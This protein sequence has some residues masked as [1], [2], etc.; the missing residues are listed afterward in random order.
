MKTSWKISRVGPRPAGL[1]ALGVWAATCLTFPAALA[2]E[3]AAKPAVALVIDDTP[4]A[5]DIKTETSFAPVAKNAAAA[6]VNVFTTKKVR[7]LRP[8]DLPFSDDPFFRRFFRD[9]ERGEAQPRTHKERSLGSG[10]IVSRDG[11]IL[12]NDHVVDGADEVKVTLAKEKKVYTAKVVGKDSKT[13]IA[14]LKIEASGLPVA[15]LTDS[16]KLE[17]G[18]VLLAIGNPFGVGQTVT[19]GI[20]SAV[21]RGDMG[22][23]DYEDFIQ[24]DAAVNPGNS[25]GALVDAQGRLVGINTAI[26]SGTGGNLGIG[27]AIPV[28]MAR[29]VMDRLVKEGRVVRGYLGVA[30]QDLTPELAK[31][32]GAPE[33]GGAL[34]TDVTGKSAA[35]EAG[36]KSGDVIIEF[37]DKPV[38]DSRRLRLLVARSSP[39]TKAIVKL[40][41]QGKEKT[42]KVTLGEA[43]DQTKGEPAESGGEAPDEVLKD[44][45]VGEIDAATRR[46]F[47]LP[48]ELKGALVTE[49]APDSPAFEAGL[50]PGDVIQEVN[51]KRIETAEEAVKATKNV[52]N[53]RVLLRVWR[54][55]SSRFL[56]VDENPGN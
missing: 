20:V 14:V 36:L 55:G 25:G 50:R 40:L 30:I 28:N 9:E 54:E 8:R 13:D 53:K 26:L 11:Y 31:E 18:D 19:K 37:D 56:V 16:D 32:F 34:V 41:R 23:E 27:F 12:T 52:K 48:P 47:N 24:T 46:Q 1:L 33:T 17:V 10:V 4:L 15:T 38:P 6:V 44:V 21:G 35:A 39:G 29:Q 51:R 49:V 45:G 42:F 22:I 3:K 43:P 5:H 2:A 7:N